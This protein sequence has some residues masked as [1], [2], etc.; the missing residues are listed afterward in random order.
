MIQAKLVVGGADHPSEHEA[1]AVADEVVAVLRRSRSAAREPTTRDGET[2]PDAA[3]IASRIRRATPGPGSQPAAAPGSVVGPEGGAVDGQLADSVRQAS[4][5]TPIEAPLQSQLE[6]AFGTSFADVR[7]H[8]SSALAPQLGAR[9]FTFGS[10]VHFAPGEYEP[11]TE[12]GMHVL[13]HELTHVVQQSGGAGGGASRIARTGRLVQRDVGFEFETKNVSTKRT[14]GAAPLPIGGF[15]DAGAGGAAWNDP[16]STRVTKGEPLLTK[17]DVEVQADDNGDNSDLEVVTTHFPETGPG[18]AR[19]VTAMADVAALV[20]A[21]D[22]LVNAG[23]GIVPAVALNGTSGFVTAMN[24]GMFGGRWATA[25]T[26]GQVTMG[27]RLQNV[28]DLVRDLHGAPGESG[29]EKLARDPGRIRMRRPDVAVPTQ[30]RATTGTEETDTLVSALG[31]AT[32]AIA[33]Y[34]LVDVNAPGGRELE[35]FL[36][37]VYAYVEAVQHKASFLKNHTPLMAKT[38]LATMWTTLPGPVQTYYGDT[39]KSG[40][41]NFEKLVATAPGYAARMSRPVFDEDL[42]VAENTK[43]VGKKQWY[44]KLTLKSWLRGIALR[45]TSTVEA[46]KQFFFGPSGSTTRRGV[47]QLTD[48]NFPGKPNGQEIEGYGVLGA[49]MDT[50]P[51]T[52]DDLPVFELRSASKPILYANAGTWATEIFDYIVSLNNNPGGGHAL[53]V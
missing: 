11:T 5:G 52:N 7:I 1:D 16:N 43:A 34:Q 37:I 47:D 25:T 45:D 41:T 39:N 31:I 8:R 12:R 38:D 50:H 18:R 48:A 44:Q 2:A 22:L 19:L 29:A 27:I 30:P 3:P 21:H 26:A 53:I 20:T 46:A 13:S 28:A 40:T 33:A 23:G 35:G 36:T 14:N 49:N 15:P 9:A 6:G 42:V 51:G 4:G 17:P 24:D 32:Q 10:D